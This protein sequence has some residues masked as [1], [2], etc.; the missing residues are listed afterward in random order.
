MSI[1][2]M[3]MPQF[4]EHLTKSRT[5]VIPLGSVEEHGPHLPFSTDTVHAYEICRQACEKTGAFLAPK[6]ILSRNKRKFWPG[7]VWGDPS[8]AGREKGV[9]CLEAVEA[10]LVNLIRQI[11]DW[12]E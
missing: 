12:K 8:K 1:E 6:G 3:A 11:E 9:R 10:V 5:L 7:G 2:S 4:E